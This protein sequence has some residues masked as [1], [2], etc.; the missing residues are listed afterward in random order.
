MLEPNGDPFLDSAMLLGVINTLTR[1][2]EQARSIAT[3]LEAE[4]SNCW[5]PMHTSALDRLPEGEV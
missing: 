3:L 5:G 2:L 1:Q 4:C